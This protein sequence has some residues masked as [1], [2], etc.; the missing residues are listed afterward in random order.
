MGVRKMENFLKKYLLSIFVLIF[1]HGCAATPNKRV[2]D[3]PV[4]KS[5]DWIPTEN[6]EKLRN[7]LG[8]SADFFNICELDRPTSQMAKSMND[9]NWSKAIDIG[10]NWI[11][12]CPIDIRVHHYLGISYEKTENHAEA[13]KHFRWFKGLM[14]LIAKSG[15]GKTPETAYVTVSI[16]EEYDA[17]Y[18]FGL[19]KKTQTLVSGDIVCDKIVAVN[20]KGDEFEI[21]FNPQ[22]HFERLNKMFK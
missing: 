15:D 12:Q 13:K 21:Y 8:S 4:S 3:V 2:N 16:T 5:K 1:L 9:G 19:R 18:Y 6:Y 10:K 22:A 20:D 7:D 17:L 14:D 11:N